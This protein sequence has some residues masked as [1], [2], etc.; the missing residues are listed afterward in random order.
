M[1][2]KSRPPGRGR[3]ATISVSVAD[4]LHSAAIHLLRRLRQS[5]KASG[6]SAPRLSALSVLVYA[7]PRTLGQL[8]E[9][10]QVRPPTM[11]RL[12]QAMEAE[13]YI[14]RI[15]DPHDKRVTVLQATA[16]ART[17]LDKARSLR[18]STVEEMMKYL[19][20][21]EIKTLGAAAKLIEAMA[22]R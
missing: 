17:L 4:R 20:P 19:T 13:G 1:T 5:D 11:T 16:R 7:G 6:I 14:K 21:A 3:A 10:E 18:V 2:R 9:A 12:V 8:A 22:K 15:T